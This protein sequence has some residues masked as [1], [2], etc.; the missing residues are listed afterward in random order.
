MKKFIFSILIIALST[1]G[2]A[3]LDKIISP[4]NQCLFIRSSS[5]TGLILGMDQIRDKDKDRY[6]SLIK[7]LS[8][9]ILPEIEDLPVLSK[10]KMYEYLD[11]IEP[12]LKDIE[13]TVIRESIL[14]IISFVENEE[15]ET[16]RGFTERI[17]FLFTCALKGALDAFTQQ[18]TDVPESAEKYIEKTCSECK[19]K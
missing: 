17:K 14:K 5:K 3:Q 18:V 7:L 19:I 13:K 9:K 15:G 6:K 4:E 11:K 16:S 2:C 8:E 1:L 12:K 10:E